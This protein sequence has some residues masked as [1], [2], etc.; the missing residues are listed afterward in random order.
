MTDKNTCLS[1][2][3]LLFLK[4]RLQTGISIVRILVFMRKLW[5]MAN[6]KGHTASQG[7]MSVILILDY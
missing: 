2:F 1:E 7:A 6:G 5:Q 3:D 4:R